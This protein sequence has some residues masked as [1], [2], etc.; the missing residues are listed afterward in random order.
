MPAAH[1]GNTLYDDVFDALFGDKKSA[2]EKRQKSSLRDRRISEK[3]GSRES[4]LSSSPDP[5]DPALQA[6]IDRALPSD[7]MTQEQ[8]VK[9]SGKGGWTRNFIRTVHWKRYKKGRSRMFMRI[10]KP[11][12]DAGIALLFVER[13]DDKPDYFAY[14]PAIKRPRRVTGSAITTSVLGTDFTYEDL[15]HFQKIGNTRSAVRSHDAVINDRPTYVL[16]TSPDENI[17]AYSSIRSYLD[18]DLCIPIK[19]EFF[20][21]NG[22]LDKELIID[23]IDVRKVDEQWVPFRATMFNRRQSSQ[24]TFE[25]E[26]VEINPK[27]PDGYFNVATLKKGR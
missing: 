6:C 20:G 10:D 18:K 3:F 4:N 26:T 9:V 11:A 8:S 24:T 5:D 27:L 22:S 12:A 14:S 7:T 16:E 21:Y 19:T 2:D 17:S 15:H 1:A 13:G 23:P 25:V